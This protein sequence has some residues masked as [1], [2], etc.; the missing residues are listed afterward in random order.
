M[1][2]AMGNSAAEWTP[3]FV[4]VTRGQCLAVMPAEA[5]IHADCD[6]EFGEPEWTPAFAGVTRG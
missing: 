1:P 5:G 6:G 2:T 4:G 3:A